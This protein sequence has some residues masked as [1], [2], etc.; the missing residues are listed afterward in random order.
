MMVVLLVA[1]LILLVA[2]VVLQPLLTMALASLTAERLSQNFWIS[3]KMEAV[4][5]PFK[6]AAS[7]LCRLNKAALRARDHRNAQTLPRLIAIAL[8]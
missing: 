6:S 1:F 3:Q 2:L 4:C 5:S 7:S 8:A